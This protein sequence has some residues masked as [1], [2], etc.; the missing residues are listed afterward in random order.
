M[1]LLAVVG[2]AGHHV[3]PILLMVAGLVGGFAVGLTGMG[4]GALMTP[5]LVLLFRVD[6]KV[7]VASDL[8]NSLVMKP[9][10]GSVHMRRGTIHWSLVGFLV[11]GSVPAAFFGAFL[12]N[13]LGDSAR[14]AIQIK[15]L[16][17]WALLVASTAIIAKAVLSARARG[18]VE[19]LG[20]EPDQLPQQV[21]RLPTFFVGVAGGLIVGM[22][23]VGS[24]SLMIVLLMLLYPR[25]SS[26]NLVGTDLVQA[27]PLV[28]SATVGQLVFGHVDFGLAG[29]LVLG[30]LPGVYLGA[31]L[32]SSAPDRIVRPVLVSIL[33]VSALALLLPNYSAL[34]WALLTVAVTA[35]PLAG[36][37]DATL[38]PAGDWK[39]VGRSRTR[40]V[41]VQGIGAPFG[42]GL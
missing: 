17:G 19:A 36:A 25:L 42:I 15:H 31:R 29:A 24:G 21:K 8:V 26:K 2:A 9:V 34:A 4:G 40:W 5:A 7:A 38:R 39:E 11:M 12:L 10:G 6:P 41:A 37:I 33:V 23:S 13:Q 1:Q 14:V 3:N 22:T 28:L 18:R 27:V 30:S 35:V 20:D 32:S 16:L